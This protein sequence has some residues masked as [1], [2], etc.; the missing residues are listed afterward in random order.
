M[1]FSFF[2][3]SF[4]VLEIFRFLYYANEGSDDVID[5]STKTI[6]YW[7]KNISRNIGAVIFKL[8][9]SNVH[10][11]RNKIALTILL[12]WQHPWLQSL[13]VKNQIFLF[14]TFSSGTGGLPQNRHGSHIVLT[15]PIKLLGVDDPCVRW[16]L[17]ILVVIK[18]GPP[19]WLL[20]WQWYDSFHF[21]SFVMYIS[22]AKFEDHCF[23]ISG[24]I[25]NAVFY[26]FRHRRPKLTIRGID[27][28]FNNKTT[29]L[30]F[31]WADTH[32]KWDVT[33]VS[34]QRCVTHA[35]GR[36]EFEHSTSHCMELKNNEE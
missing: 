27:Q 18:T 8:G 33:A 26:R 11:K 22:G 6:K 20:P 14:A 3:I 13:S 16:N 4:F 29:S 1:V 31:L 24:D 5:R 15:L 28:I 21:V 9:T 35:L 30:S 10:Q 19:A 7:I 2:G 17:G 12:P 25:L 34:A 32:I 36:W 23:N